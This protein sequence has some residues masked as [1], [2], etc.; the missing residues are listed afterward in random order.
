MTVRFVLVRPRTPGNVGS[1]ARAMKNFGFSDLVLVDPRLHR[2]GDCPGHEPAF[3]R[4]AHQMAWGAVD[5]L[6][7]AR[8]VETLSEA[9]S[10]CGLVLGTA[11][12]AVDRVR[13]LLPEEAVD[14]LAARLEAVPALVFGSESS[15]LTSVESSR[16]AGVV[17]IPTDPG[18]R[19]LNLA[20][21]AVVLAYLLHRRTHPPPD[22]QEPA[23]ASH[24]E[25]EAVA[26][27]MV[28]LG[29]RSEFLQGPEIPVAR[30]L[31]SMLH[32]AG[33]TSRETGLLRSLWRRIEYAMS[34]GKLP[35]P[36]PN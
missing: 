31:R 11:P 32:R 13:S 20:M 5:V 8:R 10:D 34:N 29:V 12:Q 27:G 1:V 2:A 28:D 24:A 33:F 25:V 30:E 7:G 23:R 36:G 3:E 9:V 16:L 26:D 4:E 22:V 18:Y 15:G 6:D 21:S 19:D 35:D 17:V 14:L